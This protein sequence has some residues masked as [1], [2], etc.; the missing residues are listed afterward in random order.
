MVAT[1]VFLSLAFHR[2]YRDRKQVGKWGLG[3]LIGTTALS[4]GLVLFTVFF[5]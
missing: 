2:T 3:M 4:I 5:R 1:F